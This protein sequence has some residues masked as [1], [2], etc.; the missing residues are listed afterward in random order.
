MGVGFSSNYGCCFLFPAPK[1]SPVFQSTS[2]AHW[3]SPAIAD[4]RNKR[5]DSGIVPPGHLGKKSFMG[6]SGQVL[7]LSQAKGH[8][9]KRD[10]LGT[11]P[12]GHWEGTE[13]GVDGDR[14][15]PSYCQRDRE[16]ARKKSL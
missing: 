10:D 3:S 4:R 12:S 7:A 11:G 15:W 1:V 13:V 9:E 14:F 6:T 2:Q 16:K 8:Y 5:D